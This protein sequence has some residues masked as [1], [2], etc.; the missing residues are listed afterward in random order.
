MKAGTHKLVYNLDDAMSCR[1]NDTLGLL[2]LRLSVKSWIKQ[3]PQEIAM[4]NIS[5]SKPSTC[6]KMQLRKKIQKGESSVSAKGEIY[7]CVYGP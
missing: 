1:S 2:L 5:A 6:Q 7:E 4:P 3:E